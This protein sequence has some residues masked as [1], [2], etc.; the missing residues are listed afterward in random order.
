MRSILN[1]FP[2]TRIFIAAV[3]ITLAIALSF[4][5]PS[6]SAQR[7]SGQAG[8]ATADFCS[9]DEDVIKQIQENIDK[10]PQLKNQIKDLRI[11]ISKKEVHL[12]GRT[13]VKSVRTNIENIA[14]SIADQC[15]MKLV[16]HITIGKKQ[17]CDGGLEW[18]DNLGKCAKKCT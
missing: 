17:G 13:M 5:T 4:V 11:E 2:S 3:S 9:K 14:K 7:K 15:Q 6:G 10:K 16:S 18:C 8:S 1:P 12:Y